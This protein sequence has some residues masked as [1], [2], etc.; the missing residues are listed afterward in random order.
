MT[1]AGQEDPTMAEFAPAIR[2]AKRDVT[3]RRSPRAFKIR[4]G[5]SLSEA[6]DVLRLHP[7]MSDLIGESACEEAEYA[8][9]GLHSWS[10]FAGTQQFPRS[11]IKMVVRCSAICGKVKGATRIEQALPL[12]T[13]RGLP[14]LVVTF[15]S[16]LVLEAPRDLGLGRWL[17]PYAL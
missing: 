16:G 10:Q 3:R 14:G 15:F 7:A 17:M 2:E 4:C 11:L 13:G 6:V 8:L 1:R 12:D 5:V 9:A